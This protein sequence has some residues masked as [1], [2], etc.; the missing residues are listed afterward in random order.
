MF[1]MLAGKEIH[2]VQVLSYLLND[3]LAC[4]AFSHG[5]VCSTSKHMLLLADVYGPPVASWLCIGEVSAQTAIELTCT[6]RMH[7]P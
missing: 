2:E 3:L 1:H 7:R 4:F 5:C 6:E